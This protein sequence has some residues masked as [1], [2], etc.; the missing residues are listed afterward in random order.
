M[1][2]YWPGAAPP[3]VTSADLALKDLEE[4]ERRAGSAYRELK[5]AHI[6]SSL[7]P[8]TTARTATTGRRSIVRW[9]MLAERSLRSSHPCAAKAP[10]GSRGGRRTCFLDTRRAPLNARADQHRRFACRCRAAGR[11]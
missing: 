5:E 11:R 6:S 4:I 8:T 7:S 9:E 2:R 1:E 10:P 3:R